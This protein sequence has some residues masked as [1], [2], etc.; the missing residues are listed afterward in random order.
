M[1]AKHTLELAVEERIL[2]CANLYPEV[3][4]SY[5]QGMVAPIAREIVR[6]CQADLLAALQ[7]LLNSY[8]ADNDLIPG[9]MIWQSWETNG[10]AIAQARA[11]LA[12]ARGE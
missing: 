5:L 8:S 3:T 4:T 6:D 2:E 12:K 7:R 11:A 9:S 1:N 10:Q